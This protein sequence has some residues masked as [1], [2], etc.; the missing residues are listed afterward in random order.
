MGNSCVVF[1]EAKN[2]NL[3]LKEIYRVLKTGGR[4]AAIDW[5]KIDSDFG[6]PKEHRLDK[7]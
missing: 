5:E 3:F 2:L 7:A 1:H 6:P 4:M